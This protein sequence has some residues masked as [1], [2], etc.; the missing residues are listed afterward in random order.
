VPEGGKD[1]GEARGRCRDACTEARS[2]GTCTGIGSKI[3]SELE[4]YAPNE[5]GQR[6]YKA[7]G[8]RRIW[9]LSFST[10]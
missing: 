1:S 3:W 5:H 9:R 4:V 6:E 10:A 7:R 2:S 8:L